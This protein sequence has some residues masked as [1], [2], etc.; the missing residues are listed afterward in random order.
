M[1]GVTRVWQGWF[2]LTFA[3]RFAF[4]YDRSNILRQSFRAR[5]QNAMLEQK[6]WAC[7]CQDE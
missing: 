5:V 1:E 6:V 7:A 3:V 4:E 2:V